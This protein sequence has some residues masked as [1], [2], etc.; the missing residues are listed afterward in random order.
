MRFPKYAA[1]AAGAAVLAAVP[2]MLSGAGPA[3]AA[4]TAAATRPGQCQTVTIPV[5]LSPGAP[6]DQ[7]LSA[8]YCTPAGEK[9]SIAVAMSSGA[10]YNHTYYDGLGFPAL[11]WV[12]MTLN[13]GMATL[14]IDPIG[15]GASSHPL[16]TDITVQSSAYTIHQAIGWLRETMGYQTV[17][18]IGHSVGSMLAVEVA[19]TWPA[20]VN[21][22]ALTGYLNVGTANG[23]AATNYAYPAADDPAFSGS[24]ASGWA[25]CPASS[26]AAG[27]CYFTTVP[28]ARATMFYYDGNPAVVSRDEATKDAFSMTLLGTGIASSLEPPASNPSSSVIAPVLMGVGQE[29]WLYC[30]GAGSA[31]CT[32]TTTLTAYEQQY[33]PHAASVTVFSEPDT[34]H[35]MALASTSATSAA[36]IINWMRSH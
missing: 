18:L 1:A 10:S 26:A 32:D 13:A 35:D 3:A 9:P 29:D 34:G 6:L 22:V 24:G 8:E 17:D 4:T 15:T 20:D 21:A 5:S 23:Q 16:S 36:T 25:S 30:E 11:S 19:A 33:F 7:S 12:S 28:G 2:L 14:A 27:A 31:D